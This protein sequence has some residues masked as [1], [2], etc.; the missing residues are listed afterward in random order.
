MASM[1]N[2][3]SQVYIEMLALK[4]NAAVWLGINKA[5]VKDRKPLKQLITNKQTN[6]KTVFVNLTILVSV[7][8]KYASVHYMKYIMLIAQH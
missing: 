3:W 1:R 4:L 7:N 5:K 8:I 6:K 2:E